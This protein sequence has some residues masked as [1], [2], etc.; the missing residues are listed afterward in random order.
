MG[1]R[2]GW[3]HSSYTTEEQLAHL[4]QQIEA[5]EVELVNREAE[6][7]DLRVELSAFATLS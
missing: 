4:R 6:L 3:Y 1:K 5:A 7:V 2:N